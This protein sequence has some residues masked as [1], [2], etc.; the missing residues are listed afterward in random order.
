FPVILS[1]EDNCSLPQ[2]RNMAVTMQE[3]F[4]DMLLV[5]PVAKHE[6]RLPSPYSLR[7]KI[8][9]KHKKLPEGGDEAS[10]MMKP[11]QGKEM[12]LRN[13]GK[14]AYCTWKICR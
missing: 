9:L 12:D 13:T 4:G 6:T 2:Q 11:E 14:R 3:V 5:Q 7:H 10:V 8:I 1:I